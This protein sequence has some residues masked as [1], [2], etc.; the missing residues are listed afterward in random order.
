MFSPG[1]KVAH[2]VGTP[3][4]V[5]ALGIVTA[6]AAHVVWLD[7]LDIDDDGRPHRRPR[8]SRVCRTP[9]RLRGDEVPCPA[10]YLDFYAG[11]LERTT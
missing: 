4:R 7:V 6:D 10:E 8:A 2:I 3:P 9:L 11:A 1:T 5:V